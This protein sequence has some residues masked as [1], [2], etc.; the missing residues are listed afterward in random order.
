[1]EKRRKEGKQIAS[2]NAGPEKFEAKNTIAPKRWRKMKGER[3]M[4]RTLKM[5]WIL[6]GSIVLVVCVMMV[7][8]V[9]N[10]LNPDRWN[11]EEKSTLNVYELPVP[12]EAALPKLA[13]EAESVFIG[14]PIAVAR[15]F[16]KAES[17][18][19]RLSWF[20][21]RRRSENGSKDI[22]SKRFPKIRLELN[23]WTW[24]RWCEAVSNLQSGVRQRGR[25]ANFGARHAGWIKGHWDSYARDGSATWEDFTSGKVEEATFRVFVN[26]GDYF[27]FDYSDEE[28]WR[29]YRMISPEMP[30]GIY[31]FVEAYSETAIAIAEA[32]RDKG[33]GLERMI[34]TVRADNT[35]SLAR[36]QLRIVSWSHGAG[37]KI[38][39][40]LTDA[41]DRSSK[42]Q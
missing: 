6:L 16:A 13:E 1:M 29:C 12:D 7:G 15:A 4:V 8:A 2:F 5:G 39:E 21:I 38:L 23:L 35:E 30:D 28:K 42:T 11:P 20:V 34:L 31:G 27:N 24:D 9:L 40:L 22:R 36:R 10:V 17:V 41:R 32:L 14:Q 26:K 19:A 37:W 33:R 18:E 3:R 25:A